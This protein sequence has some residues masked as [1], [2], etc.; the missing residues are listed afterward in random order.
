ME[1][2]LTYTAL[3][4]I[5]S[6]NL[7]IFCQKYADTH[8]H[9]KGINHNTAFQIFG[10]TRYK[11]CTKYCQFVPCWSRISLSKLA[12]IENIWTFQITFC[13]QQ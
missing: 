3:V 9:I 12:K 4:Y 10:K 6:N 8:V 5:S 7:K 2:G 1:F 11:I 13:V